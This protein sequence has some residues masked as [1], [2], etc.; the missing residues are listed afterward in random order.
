MKSPFKIWLRYFLTQQLL[1]RFLNSTNSVK[2]LA[3]GTYYLLTLS[4]SGY[5][6]SSIFGKILII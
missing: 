4:T 3:F 5:L 1:I 6:S 2:I